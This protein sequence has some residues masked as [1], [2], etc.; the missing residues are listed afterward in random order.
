MKKD[1][2]SGF[3]LWG[4]VYNVWGL[5]CGEVLVGGGDRIGRI[6]K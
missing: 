1:N 6:A 3:V 5:K 4:T 2:F